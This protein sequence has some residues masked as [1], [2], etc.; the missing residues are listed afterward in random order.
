[1]VLLDSLHTEAHVYDEL[2]AYSPLV[3]PGCYL[4]VNDTGL[5][6]WWKGEGMSAPLSAV[7]RFLSETDSYRVD[8]SRERFMLSCA[9]E[10]F[11]LREK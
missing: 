8:R 9:P 1:M 3:T 4:I 10:G 2:I 6:G 5:E 7:R 11:L